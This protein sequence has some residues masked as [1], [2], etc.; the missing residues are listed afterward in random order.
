MSF[1]F[2]KDR[3]GKPF[4]IS[5]KNTKAMNHSFIAH[6]TKKLKIS[7]EKT[8]G[9]SPVK[10]QEQSELQSLGLSEKKFTLMDGNM[11]SKK[12]ESVNKSCSYASLEDLFIDVVAP[13]NKEFGCNMVQL[14]EKDEKISIS[15]KKKG[16]YFRAQF[17]YEKTQ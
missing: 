11:I 17:G 2:D 1:S 5:L 12:S 10:P 3:Q 9:E 16:C 13:M 7:A 14:T 8:F 15:C 6:T 4:A